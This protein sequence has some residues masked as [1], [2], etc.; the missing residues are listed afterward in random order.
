MTHGQFFMPQTRK[1]KK[2]PPAKR[3]RDQRKRERRARELKCP[4]G[5]LPAPLGAVRPAVGGQ[6]DG[7]G[8]SKQSRRSYASLPIGDPEMTPLQRAHTTIC[9]FSTV[10][11]VL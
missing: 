11:M 10:E 2:F 6:I 1:S 5:P 3:E 8:F 7:T 9:S 4:K